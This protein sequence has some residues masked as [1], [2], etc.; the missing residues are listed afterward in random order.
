VGIAVVCLI[1]EQL[2]AGFSVSSIHHNSY[3]FKKEMK[4]F[5]LLYTFH[6]AEE[7][8]A[9]YLRNF[10]SSVFNLSFNTL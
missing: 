3:Y 5:L 2:M 6:L 1:F 4:S 8:V 7:P 10:V 9:L